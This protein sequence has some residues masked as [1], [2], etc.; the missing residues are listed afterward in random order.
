MLSHISPT[1]VVVERAFRRRRARRRGAWPPNLGL[2]EVG[3]FLNEMGLRGFFL[4]EMGCSDFEIFL[5]G[6]VVLYF[7]I[8]LI[9]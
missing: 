3:F 7:F 9:L 8:D 5:F 6:L 4:N 1:R 2:L